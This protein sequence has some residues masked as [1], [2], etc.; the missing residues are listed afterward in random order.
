MYLDNAFDIKTKHYSIH[1]HHPFVLEKKT[2]NIDEEN[3]K[4]DEY[5]EE[6]KKE[7]SQNN[8]IFSYWRVSKVKDGINFLGKSQD[9]LV[10]I[11]EDFIFIFELYPELE[12]E[13]CAEIEHDSIKYRI[14]KHPIPMTNCKWQISLCKVVK[15]DSNNNK[16][17]INL[18]FCYIRLSKE[19]SIECPPFVLVDSF[20]CNPK[21]LNK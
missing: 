13:Y 17:D 5:H 20:V 8:Q 21:K 1:H 11:E 12:V 9:V 19:N 16:K 7:Q 14:L 15:T 6:Q 2:Y 3:K 18:L 4:I 10:A